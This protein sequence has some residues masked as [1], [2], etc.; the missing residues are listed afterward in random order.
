MKKQ[1]KIVGIVLLNLLLVCF[2]YTIHYSR[3]EEIIRTTEGSDLVTFLVF[4]MFLILGLIVFVKSE[5]FRPVAIGLTSICISLTLTLLF[6][7]NRNC[8]QIIEYRTYYLRNLESSESGYYMNIGYNMWFNSTKITPDKFVKVDSVDVGITN[9]FFG[10]EALT[11][12]IQI[13]ESSNCDYSQ[14][15][16]KSEQQ[17]HF[18][19]AQLLTYQRCFSAAIYHYSECIKLANIRYDC[20]Y[21]RGV[22][23][24]LQKDYELALNDFLKAFTLRY[25][26]LDKK[27]IEKIDNFKLLE[28]GNELLRDIE[29]E[30]GSGIIEYLN[31]INSI[32]NFDDYERRI[33]YCVQKIKNN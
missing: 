26:N 20:Y 33:L 12:D 30:N 8:S 27:S 7:I 5:K 13:L 2:A 11:S 14:Q 1:I 22:L 24:M 21:E 15:H 23:F 16:S 28:R 10:M 29:N 6:L 32:N 25:Q 18:E 3:T 17:N 4:A 19:T 9:G 31:D